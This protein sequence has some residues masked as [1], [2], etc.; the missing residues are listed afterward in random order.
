MESDLARRAA[1]AAETPRSV[2]H[3]SRS[4]S[5]RCTKP[6]RHSRAR[7]RS[8]RREA[9]TSRTARPRWPR[10]R[11]SASSTPG[12]SIP[13]RAEM[14]E[15]DERLRRLE[16]E[17]R[18]A[19]K[20]HGFG[21]SLRALEHAACAEARRSA[22]SASTLHPPGALAQLGERRLCKPEVAG[23]IPA[24]SIEK[25]PARQGFSF[26]SGHDHSDRLLV[27]GLVN[28]GVT[29]PDR[30]QR[31]PASSRALPHL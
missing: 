29:E 1:A 20:E 14:D 23:S 3:T 2:S 22:L 9:R 26:S 10:T 4:A 27:N 13:S 18:E 7:R 16:R 15:L 12:P 5:Q 21:D 30:G 31:V 28:A 19:T 8:S 25:G 11:A 17:T 6:R 24:R